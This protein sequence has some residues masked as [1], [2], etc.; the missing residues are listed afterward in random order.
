MF[1]THVCLLCFL[2]GVGCFGF[3]KGVCRDRQGWQKGETHHLS[4]FG[5]LLGNFESLGQL[6]PVPGPT[7]AVSSEAFLINK[8]IK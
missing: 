2:R 8:H 6:T 5:S 1:K 3:G 4:G 7:S